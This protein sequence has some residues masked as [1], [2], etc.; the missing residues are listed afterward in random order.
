[1]KKDKAYEIA[2]EAIICGR[3][4]AVNCEKRSIEDTEKFAQKIREYGKEECMAFCEYLNFSSIDHDIE[5]AYINWN[6]GKR[7]CLPENE[8]E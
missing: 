7:I 3:I 2:E 1:M 6:I 8:G 5:Q 4:Q